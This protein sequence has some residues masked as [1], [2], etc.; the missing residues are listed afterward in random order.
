[1]SVDAKAFVIADKSEF[2]SLAKSVVK[3]L[4]KWIRERLDVEISS[5]E[6]WINRAHYL[7]NNKDF[8][9]GV[10][11]SVSDDFEY[12]QIHFRLS[13]E[14]RMLSMF[15]NCDCDVRHLTEK[16]VFIFSIGHWGLHEEIMSVLCNT[17]ADFGEVYYDEND[18]DDINYQVWIKGEE[19]Q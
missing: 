18:C 7:S 10:T 4:N 14:S 5:D 2:K 11:V 8:T 13:G 16:D 19:S 1:M 15:T 9:N 3:N 17:L 12:Y 6:Q